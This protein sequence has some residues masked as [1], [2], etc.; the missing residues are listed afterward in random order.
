MHKSKDYV[1][2]KRQPVFLTSL[3]KGGENKCRPIDINFYEVLKAVGFGNMTPGRG[4]MDVFLVKGGDCVRSAP[5]AVR[6]KEYGQ[7]L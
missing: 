6:H 4:P 1:M 2:H 3:A 5:P 7:L